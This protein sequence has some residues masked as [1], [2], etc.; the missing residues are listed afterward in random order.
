MEWRFIA[1]S[2]EKLLDTLSV[3]YLAIDSGALLMNERVLER[4]LL[5]KRFYFT[6]FNPYNRKDPYYIMW[7]VIE[8]IPLLA[9]FDARDP[10]TNQ[11]TLRFKGGEPETILGAFLLKEQDGKWGYRRVSEED[12]PPY[13]SCPLSMLD[14][15]PVK[16]QKWRDLVRAWAE[17]DAKR[18]FPG[19]ALTKLLLDITE[20]PFR[21]DELMDEMAEHL[22]S[23]LVRIGAES[24]ADCNVHGML[25]DEG[26]F[27]DDEYSPFAWALE[28]A[29]GGT[30][31]SNI[32][33]DV[34]RRTWKRFGEMMRQELPTKTAE[35]V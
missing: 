5:K 25:F 20:Q 12:N 1:D 33:S 11:V 4:K 30:P 18:G 32:A 23:Y 21:S 15:A 22:A 35:A 29:T 10:E 16:C 3:G 6:E 31:V 28:S 24:S 13:H 2:K 14:E 19:K 17:G 34:E 7:A 27:P 9:D 26:V 8:R